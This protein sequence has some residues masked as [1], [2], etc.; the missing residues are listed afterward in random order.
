MSEQPTSHPVARRPGRPTADVVDAHHHLWDPSLRDYPWMARPGLE[1][2][3]RRFELG[4]LQ[5]LTAD[6]G[7]RRTVLVQ[8]VSDPEET[9]SLL[10]VAD[11][12]DDVV[13]GVVGWAD[14]GDPALPARI[15]A[16]RALT[17]GHLL[18]G[19]RHQVEDEPEMDW[20]CRPEV[21]AG[22]AGV[23]R[24]GL[25][26]DLLIRPDQL[27][28]AVRAVDAVE[29]RAPE[30]RF[31]L[32]HGAKPPIGRDGWRRWAS[33]VARLAERPQVVCKLSGLFTEVPPGKP[34]TDA[35]PSAHHLLDRFGADRIAFGSD[36]PVSTLAA[37][38]DDVLRHT[39]DL[40]AGCSGDERR[41][42]LSGTATRIYR[43]PT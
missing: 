29:R 1:G 13:A 38:Y 18:V 3:R 39:T 11:A 10:S 23:A 35:E 19:L 9:A 14:L 24:A 20:L 34:L 7:V 43:L 33:D 22:L 37:T 21:L 27:D 32:D 36:W 41:A 40:L 4:E 16:L 2:L 30:G 25:V 8:A 28:S 42:V 5:A 12:S 31:V 26:F 6:A 17:G 15:D